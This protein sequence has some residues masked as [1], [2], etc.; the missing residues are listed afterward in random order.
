[1]P[2]DDDKQNG[3]ISWRQALT[4]VG[5]ALAIPSTI[6]VPVLAGWWLDKRYGTSVWLIVGLCLGLLGAAFDI[7]TLLKRF[8]Q[9]K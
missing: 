9:F 8:G 6:G 5:L 1:M 7:Y 4:T 3:G 2:S